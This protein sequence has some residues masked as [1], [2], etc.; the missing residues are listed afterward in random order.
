MT[1]GRVVVVVGG[2]VVVVL[3]GEVVVVGDGDSE[4]GSVVA[5]GDVVVVEVLGVEVAGTGK[6]TVLEAALAPGCSLATTTPM[7]MA[8]PVAA[9]AIAR[10]NRRRRAAARRLVSGL[11]D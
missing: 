8:A 4:R 1:T 5:G 7:A 3:G 6:G 2:E 11:L 10:V 9:K